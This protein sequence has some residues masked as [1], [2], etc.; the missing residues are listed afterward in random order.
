MLLD[1]TGKEI[2]QAIRDFGRPSEQLVKEMVKDWCQQVIDGRIDL[3]KI[4][5]T[6]ALE[7]GETTELNLTQFLD[8]EGLHLSF[9]LSIGKVTEKM[10]GLMSSEDKKKLDGLGNVTVGGGLTKNE[11]G[12]I[13]IEQELYDRIDGSWDAGELIDYL[14]LK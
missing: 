6:A 8:E 7:N 5:A 11:S 1:E 4:V 9:L 13:I 3:D 14:G 10:N 2:A 12:R